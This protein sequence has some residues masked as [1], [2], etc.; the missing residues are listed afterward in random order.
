MYKRLILKEME[1]AASS[2]LEKR[3]QRALNWQSTGH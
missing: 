1:I 2:M 3:L